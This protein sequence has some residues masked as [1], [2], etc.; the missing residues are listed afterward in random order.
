[1]TDQTIE[2]LTIS[3]LWAFAVFLYCFAGKKRGFADGYE[4]GVDDGHN[5]VLAAMSS[6]SDLIFDIRE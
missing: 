2:L 1:M 5:Y 6:T 4:K 3:G